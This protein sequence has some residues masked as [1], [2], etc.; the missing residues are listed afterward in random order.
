MNIEASADHARVVCEML[1]DG[2][3]TAEEIVAASCEIVVDAELAAMVRRAGAVTPEPFAEIRRR[4]EAAKVLG[5][6]FTYDCKRPAT[7][8]AW[9]DI[10]C[11]PCY[12]RHVERQRA[13]DYRLRNNIPEHAADVTNTTHRLSD[14]LGAELNQE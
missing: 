9:G 10:Y 7:V 14:L 13:R 12:E 2:G 3:W 5:P 1:A 4:R 6:C 11:R 8:E